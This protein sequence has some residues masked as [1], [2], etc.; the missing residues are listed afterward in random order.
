M[1]LPIVSERYAQN[2]RGWL[3]QERRILDERISGANRVRKRPVPTGG[4]AKLASGPGYFRRG[5][6]DVDFNALPNYAPPLRT[7]PAYDPEILKTSWRGQLLDLSLDSHRSLLHEAELRLA[8]TLRL[9][10][11]TYLCSKRRIFMLQLEKLRLGGKIR[12]TDCQ[13]G[14]R[15]DVNIASRLWTSYQ[16]AGWFESK[17]F[18]KYL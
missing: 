12:K 7:L 15:I 1:P 4:L 18:Q 9:P 2:P 8:A 14:C 6:E 11:A 3:Q 10:C 13:I 17:H 16:H 5:H